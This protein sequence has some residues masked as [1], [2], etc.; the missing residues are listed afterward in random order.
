MTHCTPMAAGAARPRHALP[1]RARRAGARPQAG[2]GAAPGAPRA[3]PR[4]PPGSAAHVT[5]SVC[6][7]PFPPSP[8]PPPSARGRRGLR[9]RGR[10]APRELHGR[11]IGAAR[12]APP[13][14]PL[15]RPAASISAISEDASHVTHSAQ[16]AGGGPGSRKRVGVRVPAPGPPSRSGRAAADCIVSGRRVLST[17]PV[18]DRRRGRPPAPPRATAPADAAPAAPP[19]RPARAQARSEGE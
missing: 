6:L 7:F 15:L 4:A 10:G 14:S 18:H 5:A 9:G 11:R 13:Q 17:S 19:P 12:A 3:R 16:G 1:A 8:F 2:P